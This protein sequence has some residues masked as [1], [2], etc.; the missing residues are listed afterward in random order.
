MERQLWVKNERKRSGQ[1][2]WGD[3]HICKSFKDIH[4]GLHQTKE[5]P[6]RIEERRT[7]DHPD[8]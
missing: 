7:L 6:K 2:E 4:K 5:N 1:R 3:F 8:E